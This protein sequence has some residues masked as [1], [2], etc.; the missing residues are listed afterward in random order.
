METPGIWKTEYDAVV[1]ELDDLREEL[2]SVRTSL[3]L[4]NTMDG[5]FREVIE[6]QVRQCLNWI[7][8]AER[9]KRRLEKYGKH[10]CERKSSIEKRGKTAQ[11]TSAPYKP[12]HSIPPSDYSC[13]A[14]RSG[15]SRAL[16]RKLL[17]IVVRWLRQGECLEQRFEDSRQ[18]AHRLMGPEEKF[19]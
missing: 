17:S 18:V 10:Y 1:Q 2:A 6:E 19:I 4:S 7:G 3:A 14:K 12:I 11:L 9:R 16:P 15:S 13:W 5:G 8:S